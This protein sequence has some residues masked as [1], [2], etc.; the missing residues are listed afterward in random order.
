MERNYTS[1]DTT[2]KER[3]IIKL[4]YWKICLFVCTSLWPGVYLEGMTGKVFY[5]AHVQE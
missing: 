5:R 2:E 4:S 1:V 3:K